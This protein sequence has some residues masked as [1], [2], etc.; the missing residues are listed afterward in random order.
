[1]GEGKISMGYTLQDVPMK[2]KE[3]ANYLASNL[4]IEPVEAY[5][6]LI[7]KLI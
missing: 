3:A 2:T 1:M 5:Q 6:L 7:E 4:Y